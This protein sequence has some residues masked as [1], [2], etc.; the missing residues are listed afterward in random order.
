MSAILRELP[1]I[2]VVSSDQA[3]VDAAVKAWGQAFETLLADAG[4]VSHAHALTINWASQPNVPLG[5]ATTSY[6][7]KWWRMDDARQADA[8]VYLRVEYRILYFATGPYYAIVPTYVVGRTAPDAAGAMANVST[9]LGTATTTTT[10]GYY[11]T[12]AA[13]WSASY[14]SGHFGIGGMETVTGAKHGRS[15]LGV[16]RIAMP[17]GT[18]ATDTTAGIVFCQG[19]YPGT[20]SW[21]VAYGMHRDAGTALSTSTGL[22]VLPW[23]VTFTGGGGSG[24]GADFYVGPVLVAAP[25][26]RTTLGW[27]GAYLADVTDGQVFTGPTPGGGTQVYRAQVFQLYASLNASLSAVVCQ[28]WEV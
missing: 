14:A 7:W 16:S 19:G 5:T 8:P 12:V 28:R 11:T 24:L 4:F 3:T 23:P 27:V 22:C 26:Q 17:D 1:P 13:T 9:T 2:A 20:T 25:T 21:T 6:G 18:T 15:F 10:A